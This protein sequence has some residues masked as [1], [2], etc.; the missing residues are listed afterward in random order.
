MQ[1]NFFSFLVEPEKERPAIFHELRKRTREK[2]KEEVPRDTKIAF[3]PFD[4][5]CVV[6]RTCKKWPFLEDFG[7]LPFA[8]FST[9]T[10]RGELEW[11]A[12]RFM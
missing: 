7:S 5:V 12:I 3:C 4:D 11:L 9:L 1:Q 8:L 10:D 6:L 2:D